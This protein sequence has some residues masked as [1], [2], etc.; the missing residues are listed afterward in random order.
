MTILEA[1]QNGD[2]DLV[3]KILEQDPQAVHQGKPGEQAIHYASW[4]GHAA[5][6]E[7]LLLH[8]ADVDCE[9]A[10]RRT[11]SH[12]AA[13]HNRPEVAR[14]L[15]MHYASLN[16]V[17]QYGFTPAVYAIRER[18]PEGEE[19]FHTLLSA[20]A[21]YG[22]HEAVS[23]GDAGR[24][25]E[26]LKEDA[27]VVAKFPNQEQLLTDTVIGDGQFD[28]TDPIAIIKLLFDNGLKVSQEV[29]DSEAAQAKTDVAACLR[30]FRDRSGEAK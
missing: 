17:D 27:S 25:R 26:L 24:V 12:Y 6:V 21:N 14:K 5:I 15:A 11:P 30:E 10:E 8:G 9:D 29:I 13:L 7:E 2:L 22:I 16:K 1:A 4:F 28:G 19:I 3:K 23:R 18:T 20:G